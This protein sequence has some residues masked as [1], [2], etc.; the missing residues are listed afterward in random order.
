MIVRPLI[1]LDYWIQEPPTIDANGNWQ[2]N[3]HIGEMNEGSGGK[4]EILALATHENF[5]VTWVTGNSLPIGKRQDLP[6]STN[7]SNIVTVTRT[8]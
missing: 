4:Y 8:R 2:A 7:R 5:L 1:P 3:V 6:N